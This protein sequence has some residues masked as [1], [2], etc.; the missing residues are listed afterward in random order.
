MLPFKPTGLL[1]D[2]D[3]TLIDGASKMSLAHVPESTVTAKTA[4]HEPEVTT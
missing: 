1:I 4:E 2:L 3:G